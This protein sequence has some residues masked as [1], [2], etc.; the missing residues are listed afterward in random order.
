M[1]EKKFPIFLLTGLI[2]IILIVLLI[3]YLFLYYSPQTIMLYNGYAIEPK[4]LSDNLQ[5]TNMDEVDQSISMIKI[6]ED[7]T[8]FKKLNTYY[9]GDNQ[10]NKID[11][12]YPIYIDGKE[13]IFNLSKD[14][15]LITVNYEIVE[16]YPEFTMADGVMYNGDDLLRADGN[17][18]LFLKS[19]ENIYTNVKKINIETS[20]NKY[21]IPIYSQLYIAEDKITYYEVND[22]VM[23][24][25]KI[26]DIDKTSKIKIENEE[27]TYEEF[28]Q[29]MNIIS[30]PKNTTGTEKDDE[31]DKKQEENDN[32]KNNDNSIKTDEKNNIENDANNSNVNDDEKNNQDEIYK[33]PEVTLTN[34]TANVYTI[35]GTLNIQNE[36]GLIT[37]A[38]TFEIRKKGKLVKRISYSNSGNIQ[39]SGLSPETEIE[40][41][42]KYSYKDEN[43]KEQKEE[44][45]NTKLKTKG[46]D[47]LGTIKLSFENGEI[48][49]NKIEIKQ[50]KIENDINEE[51]I[52][53]I[54][55]IEI[56][57]N[58]NRLKVSK[59][60]LTQLLKGEEITYQS[61]ESVKSNSKVE[62]E[63]YAYDKYGNTLKIENNKGITRTS[64]EAPTVSLKMKSQ[65][66]TQVK[67]NV[68]LKN[69]NNIKIKNYRY[70]II[71]TANNQIATSYMDTNQKQIILTEMNPNDYYTIKIF[72]DYDLDDDR[73]Y[74]E[75]QLL[76]ETKFTTLPITSLGYVKIITELIELNTNSAKIK[77]GIDDVVT[78]KRLAGILSYCN[79]RILEE[80][81][82]VAI[83]KILDDDLEKIKNSE[84]VEVSLE[85]LK[86]NTKYKIEILM[87]AKQGSAEENVQVD[88]EMTEFTTFKLPAEVQIINQF[89]TENMIDFDI[90]IED[91]DGAILNNK[92][93]LELRDGKTNIIERKEIETNK[94]FQREIYNKLD[95]NQTYYLYIYALEYNEGDTDETYQ[96][97]YILKNVQIKTEAGISG[98]LD[99]ISIKMQPAGKNLINIASENNWYVYPNFGTWDYYGKE[100]NSET[101]ELKIG[102]ESNKRT[103]VY[104]LQEYA[105]Q[106]VTISFK[107]KY[108]DINNTGNIYLQNSKDGNHRN[109]IDN[110]TGEYTEKSYT[111]Q[112]DESGYLGFY[113]NWGKGAYIKD[114][115]V[116][117]GSKKTNYEEFK[118]N[119][120]S[121]IKI[122]L[123]DKKDEI[124]TNDYYI[125]IYKN[126]QQVVENRYEEITENNAI[127]T[128][129]EFD[130]DIKSKYKIE[131]LIKVK[132]RYYS[133]SSVEFETDEG[134]EIKGIFSLEDYFEIQ[135]NGNYIVLT[136]LDMSDIVGEK[137]EFGKYNRIVF[138]G[139]LDF[140]GHKIIREVKNSAVDLFKHIGPNA[141][142]K[143][144]VLDL[145]LNNPVEQNNFEGIFYSNYGKISNIQ[146][147]ILESTK[148]ANRAMHM[149]G[150]F[151]YGTI[152]NF[153]INY[154][155]SVYA[156]NKVDVIET[157]YGTVKNGYVYGKNIKATFH[158]PDSE[159]RA[160]TPLVGYNNGVGVIKNIYSLVSVDTIDE[161]GNDI[162]NILLA[163]YGNANVKNTYSVG[164]GNIYD[165]KNGPNIYITSSVN[166]QDNYYFSDEIFLNDLHKKT[167][168]LALWDNTFQNQILNDENQFI[169]EGLV[170][171]GYYPQVKMSECM[172][173]QKYI[174]LPEVLDKDLVDILATEVLDQSS[175]RTK[176]RFS[177]NNPSAEKITEIKIENINVNILEQ[178]YEDGKSEVIAELYDPI[179]Y[180]SSYNLISIT[181]KGAINIPYTRTFQQGERIIYVDLF[182]EINN[183][184]E[185]KEMNNSPTENYI[186]MTDLNFIN[187]LDTIRITNTFTG[188]LNGNNH[189]IKNIKLQEGSLFKQ[190]NGNMFDL[191]ISNFIENN[192]WDDSNGLIYKAEGATIDNVH[193]KDVKITGDNSLKIFYAGALGTHFKNTS[194]RNCSANNVDISKSSTSILKETHIG[195]LLEY[196]DTCII[197]NTYTANLKITCGNSLNFVSGGLVGAIYNMSYIYNCYV[198]NGKIDVK[199]NNVGGIVG[200]ASSSS[201]IQKTYSYIK[202]SSE[203]NYIGG[204]AGYSNSTNIDNISNNLSIGDIYSVNNSEYLS[205]SIGD[206]PDVVGKNFAYDKQK[207]NGYILEEQLGANLLTYQKLCEKYTYEKEIGLDEDYNYDRVKDGILPKLYNTSRTELLPNQPD[208]KIGMDSNLAIKENIIEKNENNSISMLLEI[209]N[210]KELLIV[211]LQIENMDIK[212]LKN[213]TLD[214]ITYLEVKGTP[215][216]YYD[217]YMISKINYIENNET[218]EEDVNV[219]IEA[220]FYKELYTY[221]DWQAIEAGTYQNY[222][223]LG[224][225]DFTGKNDINKNVTMAR[226]ESNGKALKNIE[227]NADSDYSGLIKEITITLNGVKFENIKVTA[228]RA[229]NY[230]G[231]IAN[232]K[233][234]V[235]DIE[236]KQIV[237]ET[238]GNNQSSYV[239]CIANTSGDI[240]KNV[241]LDDINIKGINYV[242]G[243]VAYNDMGLDTI[244]A[245]KVIINA[246][247][248]NVGGL[249]TLSNMYKTF[250]NLEVEDSEISGTNY[251]GGLVA[252]Y[253]GN[254]GNTLKISNSKITGNTN[255]G[256]IA[257]YCTNVVKCTVIDC[258]IIGKS[259]VGGVIGDGGNLHYGAVENTNVI[260]DDI[261]SVKVGGIIGNDRGNIQ[262]SYIKNSSIITKGSEVGG[263]IGCY[264]GTWSGTIY[265]DL[266]QNVVIQGNSN[267]GGMI[268][269]MVQGTVYQ[270]EINAS[271]NATSQNAGGIV[272]YLEN[273]EM[274]AAT[275]TI[276]IYNNIIANS[277]IISPTNAG[278]LIGDMEKE[279]YTAEDKKFIYSNLV[280][281]YLTCDDNNVSF[282]IAGFKN[283]NKK[284]EDVYIYRYNKI[285]NEYYKEGMDTFSISETFSGNDLKSYKTYAEVMKMGW[286]Y[287][288]SSLPNGKYPFFRNIE[289]HGGIDLPT[290]P[291]ESQTAKLQ[292]PQ[293]AQ[294]LKKSVNLS[295]KK[296]SKIQYKIYPI[297]ANEI[298]IDFSNIEDGTSLS[299]DG[300]EIPITSKTLTFLYDFKTPKNL[301]L[302]KDV[303]DL[304]T[305][306]IKPENLKRYTTIFDD[307]YAY[308]KNNKLLINEKEQEGEFLNIYGERALTN[309]GEI[310]NVKNQCIEQGI[311]KVDELLLESEVKPLKEYLYKDNE[312]K[313][314]GSY[315]IINGEEKNQIYL[316]RNGKISILSNELEMKTGEYIIECINNKEYETILKQDGEMQ[317]LKNKIKYPENFKNNEILEINQNTNIDLPEVIV[318]YKNG[319]V[320]VFN[321]LTGE[322]K[323]N[324]IQLDISLFTKIQ[325]QIVSLFENK[326]QKEMENEYE[327]TT[328]LIEILKKVPVEEAIAQSKESNMSDSKEENNPKEEQTYISSYNPQTK[329]YDIYSDNEIIK[330]N[331]ED[332]I[333]ETKKIANN[334]LEKFY[335]IEKIKGEDTN[336]I[337]GIIVIIIII[338]IIVICII[339][340][341]KIQKKYHK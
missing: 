196:A 281:A 319:N 26:S 151:N 270:S 116:E 222:K 90:R 241:V 93:V 31:E 213:N 174:E 63:I 32:S 172:P 284:L 236:F 41:I 261:N 268:G 326:E 42:G 82:T 246:T 214:G 66:V 1:K 92:V 130:V 315:S 123:E 120:N 33:K 148:V 162:A 160:A 170:D 54:Y 97:N 317:D 60:D 156:S 110:I 86:S 229:I 181:S 79:L 220:Q 207:I 37:K 40:I 101:K 267:V 28:L 260:S 76:G 252:N 99:L 266:I 23:N 197:E 73:G 259:Y 206:M 132:E 200:I 161:G 165:V 189:T 74:Q 223:L 243:L 318:F 104:D 107:I 208:I 341:D 258:E 121:K 58:G 106:T 272:G 275:R 10:K 312:I 308:I 235:D 331:D 126:G 262:N 204:I 221:E 298:N 77:L 309:D 22:G 176:V 17:E 46:V 300:I 59:K 205:R 68:E 16:G 247:G 183:I 127:E 15:Q 327:I 299:I 217:S 113:S 195:G 6:K 224:D 230:L 29:K 48:Y 137:I 140:N 291:I 287:D 98:K 149:L 153:V 2:L 269:Y 254:T 115:Q 203:E 38:P 125:R 180:T 283:D 307:I 184:N 53:G 340:G 20:N 321:Y 212:I 182:K 256:G 310:F 164:I 305:I 239:G 62:Y 219:K 328:E 83:E 237:I 65:E 45:I 166:I 119:L 231:V 145:K 30:K 188:K 138:N 18:Y 157:N 7:D 91:T 43:G 311:N 135:P 9:I 109:Y 13:V 72:G 21:E 124:T 238:N 150:N 210:P 233:A 253:N 108:V 78:D 87:K 234:S 320:V 336:T 332:P 111:L 39:I 35:T 209:D 255:V 134:K 95:E 44:F 249:V 304:L 117:L 56:L 289:N 216:K 240:M 294:N 338:V 159:A 329:K 228:D 232:C 282:G 36:M 94:E 202:L 265:G 314:Y 313:V 250:I 263:I 293:I 193:L 24:Y 225:I 179:K 278:G 136:D 128:F 273:G 122:S 290:D 52:K 226:L 14:T 242:A 248:N 324:G 85:Q 295:K 306:S 100:Y 129:K 4:I 147:N 280:H 89:V 152:E 194:I 191:N 69:N 146:V 75:N 302:R 5:N 114:L 8:I 155:S 70:E 334:G 118:Y 316:V 67:I 142:L 49:S 55:K 141:V 335:S 227:I 178:Q 88:Y 215:K 80:D 64:K 274:T 286:I 271:V 131:L 103:A 139:T 158:K 57:A 175:N 303:E 244:T 3:Y 190:F 19:K 50:F 102:Y 177:V 81:G 168:K 12:N 325:N 187:E 47:E 292:M 96:N 192:K 198:S 288:Y 296:E 51:V 279:L 154:E 27:L 264:D 245:K 323:N 301:I 11:I 276:R 330:S 171:S 285:N 337:S 277:T 251:V 34:L 163:N 169:V 333:S 167:T 71:D 297:S 257:G 186:L 211:N 61:D 105:G 144:L 199:S 339:I 112:L 185:W 133:I 201:V 84:K 173:R 218:K 25:K 322:I 143:N